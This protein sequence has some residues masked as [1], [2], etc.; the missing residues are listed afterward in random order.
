MYHEVHDAKNPMTIVQAKMGCMQDD[1][2]RKNCSV[3]IPISASM[4]L[5]VYVYYEMSNY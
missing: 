3:S 2:K 5:L 4:Q 1:N